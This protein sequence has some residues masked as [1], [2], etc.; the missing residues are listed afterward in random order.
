MALIG[1]GRALE[2]GLE[3][4]RGQRI[5]GADGLP[6]SGVDGRDGHEGSVGEK[7]GRR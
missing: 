2:A 3:L 1:V 4:R 5:E 7:A 6:R